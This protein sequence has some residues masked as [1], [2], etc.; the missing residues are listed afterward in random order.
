MKKILLLTFVCFCSCLFASAQKMGLVIHYNM[1]MQIPKEVYDMNDLSKRQLVINK[2]SS[3]HQSYTLFTNGNE[4]A[5]STTDIENN[6]IRIEG[7][8][9]FY[10]NMKDHKEIGI[11]NIIDKPFVVSSDSL[12]NEWDIFSDDTVEVL[13]KLCSKAVYKRNKSVIAWFCP[14]IPLPVGPCGYVGLPGAILRLVT[15]SAIYE[16]TSVLPVKEKINIELPKGKAI[17][18]QAFEKLMKKKIGELKSNGS[19]GN[20]IVL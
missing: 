5:F 4:C 19:N 7:S 10:T 12:K 20:V 6:A 11:K 16:A 13:G 1:A 14:E 2:L 8:G 17:Q 9:S 3:Q 18:K 15:S